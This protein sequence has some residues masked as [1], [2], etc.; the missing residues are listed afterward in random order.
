VRK[1][2]R[3]ALIPYSAKQMYAL[4]EDVVAYPEFLPWCTGSTLHSKDS[5]TIE[6]SLELQKSGVTKSFRTRN[7]LRADEAMGIELVGGPFRHLLGEWRFEQLGDEGS[8]VS[9]DLE[10]EFESRL[11]D[12]IFG[13]YFED[14]CNSLI[15]SFTE[16]AHSMYG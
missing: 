4:V 12:T 8:K 9:L 16:R 10:F 6:A 14:T 1:V 11:T 7:A 5:D 3:T 15:D 13:R 2:S